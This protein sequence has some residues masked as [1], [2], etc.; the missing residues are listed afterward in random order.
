MQPGSGQQLR[1]G[2]AA[3]YGRPPPVYSSSA[4]RTSTRIKP[5]PASSAMRSG[6]RQALLLPTLRPSAGPLDP[7][8]HS[9]GA[10]AVPA[11]QA[12]CSAGTAAGGAAAAAPSPAAAAW[13]SELQAAWGDRGAAAA[14]AG[15]GTS[16]VAAWMPPPAPANAAARAVAHVAGSG[17]AGEGADT[18]QEDIKSRLL[19]PCCRPG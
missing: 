8:Q 15:P 16:A 9:I 4:S 13:L 11:P 10:V 3:P 14:A 7:K 18:S 2:D 19:M 5:S 6:C 12:L 1:Q 17:A